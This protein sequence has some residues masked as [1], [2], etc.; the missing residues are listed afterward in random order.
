[1]VGRAKTSIFMLVQQSDPNLMSPP[2]PV[3]G[4]EIGPI[5]EKLGRF[6]GD[7]FGSQEGGWWA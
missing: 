3:S 6:L 4:E 5:E 1:M 7:D 2:I